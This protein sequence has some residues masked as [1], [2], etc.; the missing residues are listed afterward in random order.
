MM[1]MMMMT[2]LLDSTRLDWR[3]FTSFSEFIPGFTLHVLQST[4]IVSRL[5]NET[6]LQHV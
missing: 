5:Q 6:M 1:M 2:W 4:S 3:G